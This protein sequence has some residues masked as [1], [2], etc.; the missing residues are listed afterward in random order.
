MARRLGEDYYS[1]HDIFR[2]EKH[3]IFQEL[4]RHNMDE[5]LAVIS[6]NFEE[7]RPLLK[8]MAA[9]GLPLPRL[10]QAAGEISLNHFL[11]GLLRKLENDPSSSSNFGPCWAIFPSPWN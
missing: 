7:A 5:A 2:D 6:H 9:E 3:E 4:L 8:A 1:F 11:V 10:Y